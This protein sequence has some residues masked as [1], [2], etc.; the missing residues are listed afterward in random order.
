[1]AQTVS[2]FTAVAAL[3]PISLPDHLFLVSAE[4]WGGLAHLLHLLR[5]LHLLDEAS[6][7][8]IESPLLIAS[9][10]SCLHSRSFPSWAAYP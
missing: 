7:R 3:A 6:E 4:T 9:Q 10:F 2:R 8:L 5:L 1:M